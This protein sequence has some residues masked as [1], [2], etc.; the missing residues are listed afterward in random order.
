MRTQAHA[1]KQ[2]TILKRRSGEKS[3]VVRRQPCNAFNHD[4]PLSSMHHQLYN[5][6]LC[7]FAKGKNIHSRTPRNFTVLAARCPPVHQSNS[8]IAVRA[9]SSERQR[10]L[11]E[12]AAHQAKYQVLSRHAGFTTWGAGW[13]RTSLSAGV[14]R[15]RQA[16]HGSVCG[17]AHE[18]ACDLMQGAAQR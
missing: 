9:P 16:A 4:E 8:C 7:P 1:S 14:R 11:A 12:L 15:V 3:E 2:H 17:H 10:Y 5:N 6:Q 18:S 13:T